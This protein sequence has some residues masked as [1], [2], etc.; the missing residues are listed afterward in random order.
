[1]SGHDARKQEREIGK[2]VFISWANTITH[3][4]LS[5]LLGGGEEIEYFELS[6]MHSDFTNTH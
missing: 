4:T 6:F 5:H 2:G 1:M 3:T